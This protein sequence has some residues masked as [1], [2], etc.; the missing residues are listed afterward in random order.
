MHKLI[1]GESFCCCGKKKFAKNII[2]KYIY[3]SVYLNAQCI[4][5]NI[6]CNRKERTVENHIYMYI[7][8]PL[9]TSI[10]RHYEEEKRQKEKCCT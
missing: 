8:H 2:Y 10:I 1:K 5:T 3:R 9:F 6:N 4:N 7:H